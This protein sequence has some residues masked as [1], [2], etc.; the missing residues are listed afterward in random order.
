MEEG[1]VSV[2]GYIPVPAG[3]DICPNGKQR[4]AT[5]PIPAGRKSHSRVAGAMSC[6]SSDEASGT[7]L[8]Y[9]PYQT[10]ASHSQRRNHRTYR[11][12]CW[13]GDEVQ[14]QVQVPREEASDELYRHSGRQ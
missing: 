3:D 10:S 6:S 11:I 7:C 8:S 9:I 5:T 4:Q 2:T 13:A 12:G 1:I 14:G